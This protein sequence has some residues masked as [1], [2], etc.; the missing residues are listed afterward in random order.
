[1]KFKVGDIVRLT[2]G[3]APLEV[4]AVSKFGPIISA[5]YVSGNYPT[6][7]RHADRFVHFTSS[8]EPDP[9]STPKLY[10]TLAPL[11]IQYGS[12]LA[13]NS[14]GLIVFEVK[15]TQE[16][17]TIRP[18]QFEEVRPH[19]V[20]TVGDKAFETPP[21]LLSV[22]DVI[23]IPGHGM[24]TIATVD[25]KAQNYSPLPPSTRRVL[26]EALVMSR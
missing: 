10:V 21:G 8:K 13:K 5:R 4:I 9:M 2:T 20:T 26:M 12:P 16:L 15:A 18:D 14:Q 17:L 23:M 7:G 6:V 24:H 25:S 19:T 22:G 1:M 11:P 3:Y